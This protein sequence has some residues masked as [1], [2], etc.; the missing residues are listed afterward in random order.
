[1][2]GHPGYVL[3]N[4]LPLPESP[5]TYSMIITDSDRAVT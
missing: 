5:L 1:M 2:T 3:E 4:L